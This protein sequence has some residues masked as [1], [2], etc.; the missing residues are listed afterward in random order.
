M[1][2]I[3]FGGLAVA[4]AGYAHLS[5]HRSSRAPVSLRPVAASDEAALRATTVAVW[6]AIIARV[7][8]AM[9]SRVWHD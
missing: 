9:S 1:P 4:P 6:S 2:V 7:E 3:P 5:A 8:P